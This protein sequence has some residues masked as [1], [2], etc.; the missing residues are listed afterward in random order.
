MVG[1]FHPVLLLPEGIIERLTPPQLDAVLA[2][3]PCHVRRRDNLTAAIHMIVEAVFWF[4]PLVWWIGVRLVKE[5]ERACDEEVLRLGSKPQVYAEGILSVCKFYVESPLTCVAGVTGANLR[6]RVELIMRNH[7]GTPLNLWRKLL[8]TTAGVVALAVPIVFGLEHATPIL[9]E[10]HPQEAGANVP[11]YDVV[12]IK[13]D[14]SSGKNQYEKGGF[15]FIT[16]TGV[17]VHDLVRQAYG[18]ED[19]QIEGGPN[20]LNSDRYNIDA[21]ATRPDGSIV[22]ELSRLG[23]DV[24]RQRVGQANQFNLQ[25]ILGGSLPAHVPPRNQE[26]SSIRIGHRQQWR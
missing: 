14:K 3:E 9:A 19:S 21:K 20:W 26:S 4:H 6:K 12:L 23:G 15:Y 17:T 18:V 2:H 8:L 25:A 7:V 13:P 24:L 5:R 22:D 10:A 11:L 1:L 16:A